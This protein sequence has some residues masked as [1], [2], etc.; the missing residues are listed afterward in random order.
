MGRNPH[1]TILDRYL[2]VVFPSR[3]AAEG[4]YI[5]EMA[6]VHDCSYGTVITSKHIGDGPEAWNDSIHRCRYFSL[7][8]TPTWIIQQPFTVQLR[9]M[10]PHVAR[11][12]VSGELLARLKDIDVE[13]TKKGDPF[14]VANTQ[15]LQNGEPI[16]TGGFV[17]E[18]AGIRIL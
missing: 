7:G 10:L 8:L 9:Q 2:R 13:P 6:T 14:R 11:A 5:P 18:W 1:M 15:W 3:R 4:G 17:P 16:N 12:H